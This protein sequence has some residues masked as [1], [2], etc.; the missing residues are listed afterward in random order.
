MPNRFSSHVPET[1]KSPGSDAHPE[2]DKMV[3]GVRDGGVGSGS[4]ECERRI[5]EL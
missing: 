4:R 3:L 1:T 5:Q 2:E